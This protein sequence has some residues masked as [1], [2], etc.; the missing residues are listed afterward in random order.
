MEKNKKL[1][2]EITYLKIEHES[3]ALR[4]IEILQANRIADKRKR[5]TKEVLSKTEKAKSLIEEALREN[6]GIIIEK[7]EEI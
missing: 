2:T 3:Q 4:M 1:S 6:D 7:D 5:D